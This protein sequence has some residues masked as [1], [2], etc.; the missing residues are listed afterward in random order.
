EGI[1]AI[2]HLRAAQRHFLRLYLAAAMIAAGRDEKGAMMALRPP[3]FWKEEA[4]FR[5]ELRRWKP[6]ALARALQGLLDAEIR[7][8]SPGAAAELIAGDCL[9]DLTTAGIPAA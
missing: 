1:P 5:S 3:V 6:R 9:F 7:C 4:A 8:K 2:A